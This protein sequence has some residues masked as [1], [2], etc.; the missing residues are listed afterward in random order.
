MDTKTA[1]SLSFV[2]LNQMECN[3]KYFGRALVTISKKTPWHALTIVHIILQSLFPF[4]RVAIRLLYHLNFC[5]SY[6]CLIFAFHFYVTLKSLLGMFYCS[7]TWV[8]LLLS[9]YHFAFVFN[10]WRITHEQRYLSN[11]IS[12]VVFLSTTV[13][14][15]SIL[16]PLYRETGWW[17][18]IPATLRAV[19]AMLTDCCLI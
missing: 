14:S 10:C 18:E 19:T 1:T 3:P 13:H 5:L 2:S 7:L 6:C 8:Y 9:I 4:S 11:T 12:Y 16:S 15:Q 17:E